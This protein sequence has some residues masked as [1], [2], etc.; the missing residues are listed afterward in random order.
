[1]TK[2]D[3]IRGPF[4]YIIFHEFLKF[5]DTLASPLFYLLVDPS[6]C[7][8]A[9]FLLSIA[10]TKTVIDLLRYEITDCKMFPINV[11]NQWQ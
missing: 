5:R 4:N 7:L 3:V 9:L 6:T 11:S 8:I 1:M 10:D 2:S